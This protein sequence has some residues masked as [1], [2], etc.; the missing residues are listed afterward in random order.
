MEDPNTHVEVL[1][2]PVST[3]KG[4]VCVAGGICL[5]IYLGCF[6]LWGNISTYVLSYFWYI[7]DDLSYDFIFLVDTFLIISNWFGYQIG[8]YLFM[9]VGINQRIVI[10]LGGLISL[11]GVF[12]SSYT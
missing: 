1:R 11:V 12:C 7:D 10:G 2:K 4:V 5:M 9:T 6:F 8:V 3:Y